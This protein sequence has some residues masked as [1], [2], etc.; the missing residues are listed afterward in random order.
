[1]ENKVPS[2]ANR[3][4]R[5]DFRSSSTQIV[6]SGC[7]N[8][9]TLPR[10]SNRL[11]LDSKQRLGLKILTAAAIGVT[12]KP[13]VFTSGTRA[14][15]E[16][17]EGDLPWQTPAGRHTQHYRLL[18]ALN[19][20]SPN[21]ATRPQSKNMQAHTSPFAMPRLTLS[22]Q[23]VINARFAFGGPERSQVS[24]GRPERKNRR[25]QAPTTP[26]PVFGA[27]CGG[28][29]FG[30]PATDPPNAALCVLGPGVISP[31]RQC[32]NTL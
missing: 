26:F 18:R 11:H 23:H 21:R 7:K 12:P 8:V 15:P 1:M 31:G 24:S 16:L 22:F 6:P 2:P 25:G 30:I 5:K 13:P 9:H 32:L 28:S 14:C 3:P 29:V 19:E 4:L 17:A 27:F 20:R 10:S